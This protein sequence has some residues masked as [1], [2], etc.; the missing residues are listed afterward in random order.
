MKA[1]RPL[2]LL[3]AIL[4]LAHAQETH[5]PAAPP[6]QPAAPDIAAELLAKHKA[7]ARAAWGAEII[8]L[9]TGEVLYSH[10][11]GH[12]FVPASNTKLFSTSLALTR[13]G[14]D[15][16]FLTRVAATASPKSGVLSGDLVIVGSGDPSLS[17]RNYPYTKNG[18]NGDPLAA[19][20]DLVRQLKDAGLRRVTGDIIGDDRAWV[21]EPY[22][23][24]WAENDALYEYGAPV[25][26]LILNDNS[27]SVRIR[28]GD[29]AAAPARVSLYPETGYFGIHSTL[30]TI[31]SGP[32]RV[33]EER[34]PGSR[35]LRL[36]GEIPLK[37]GSGML[38]AVDDPAHYFAHAF[39][40]ALINS[41]IA[42]DGIPRARH[43]FAHESAKPDPPPAVILATR[44]SPPLA[45]IVQVVNKVSQ[46]L[47]AEMLL[48]ESSRSPD[49]AA[50]RAAALRIMRDFLR[51][52]G[53]PPSDY[54]LYDGSGLS[55]LTLLTPSTC[56]RLLRH[57]HASPLRDVWLNSLPVG[58]WDGTLSS[59]FR[60]LAN[61]AITAGGT[62]DAPSSPR[63]AAKTGTLT[64]VTA[65]SGYAYTARGDT[66]AFSVMANNFNA[67]AAA[68][69]TFI[70]ELLM[71]FIK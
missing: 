44:Q 11:A 45:E 56:T 10:N 61:G 24:G 64:H 67:N 13:L 30:A 21:W 36:H 50:S 71:L 54:A 58:G 52:A 42:V 20:N 1:H 25:S 14:P 40:E 7:V 27:V 17:S 55:R 47:H 49:A 8:N 65:L 53:I 37:G 48:R 68:A 4:R 31:A 63:V 5:A 3:A 34:A 38:L 6:P 18:N 62:A 12:F 59:R 29:T 19:I 35:T 16:R 33:E 32:A 22:P 39:R 51:T 26:A 66:L 46:N 57:M 70:D 2:L 43:R 69:R 60:A 23:P 9:S 41:G 15:H 28:P